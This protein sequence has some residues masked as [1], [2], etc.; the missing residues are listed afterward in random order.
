MY[1]PKIHDSIC[2]IMHKHVTKY[3]VFLITH[4]FPQNCKCHMENTHTFTFYMTF[5]IRFGVLVM[6]M[7]KR[8][9]MGIR[10]VRI[11]LG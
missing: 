3:Q 8:D 4:N 1:H 10:V 5:C 11:G 9:G 6:G 7:V 2:I